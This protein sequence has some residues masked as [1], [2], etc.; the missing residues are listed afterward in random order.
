MRRCGP[1][2]KRRPEFARNHSGSVETQRNSREACSGERRNATQFARIHRGSVETKAPSHRV[3]CCGPQPK[4]PP[5][6][7]PEEA[8]TRQKRPEVFVRNHS[9]SI[10]TQRNSR[11]TTERERRNATEF[12]R[13]HSESVETNRVRRCG[14]QP[15]RPPQEKPEEARVRAKPQ[16][17]RRN[18]REFARN[19]SGSVE[20]KAPPLAPLRPKRPPQER[21]RGQSKPE[22]AGIRAK[23]QRERRNAREFGRNHSGSIE[24][25]G[26]SRETTAGASKRRSRPT[27][28]CA[29]AARYQFLYSERKNPIVQALFGE[30]NESKDS[31]NIFGFLDLCN[32]C[33]YASPSS[34][35]NQNTI[36]PNIVQALS[37]ENT[38][39]IC[40][41]ALFE[42]CLVKLP[43]TDLVTQFWVDI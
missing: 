17:E 37:W 20:T 43:T 19:Q 35:S 12:A 32:I 33:Q 7:R 42:V 38:F 31:V 25:Q 21:R 2:P 23:S 40:C 27:A 24:T 3:R 18:A 26:N 1:Q 30:I 28:A 10:E 13:N 11:E 34:G 9:G 41:S 29:V 4:R 22:E 6:K 8:R 15:K 39:A 14:P 36:Q 16:R 5:Q